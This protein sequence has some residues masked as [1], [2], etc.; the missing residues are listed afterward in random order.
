MVNSFPRERGLLSRRQQV[1]SVATLRFH[2]RS[3]RFELYRSVTG[4]NAQAHAL[5]NQQL[6]Q[7][8]IAHAQSGLDVEGASGNL[9]FAAE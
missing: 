2:R 5:R 6:R 9:V 8:D 3:R 1:E 7:I 4:A